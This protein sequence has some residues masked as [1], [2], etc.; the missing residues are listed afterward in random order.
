MPDRVI[1][2]VGNAGNISAIW[3]GFKE[4]D[5]LGFIDKLP[6]MTGIQA[7][8][9]APIARAIKNGKSEI[10]PVDKPETIASAIRIGAPVSWKKAMN[11]IKESKG[12]AEIVTDDEILEAQKLL[13]RSEGLFIE[14]ASAASIAGLKK[15]VETGEI[16]RDEVVVCV[17]TGHGLKD[18]DTAMKIS[19][20][21][22]EID[23]KIESV[24]KFLGLS[25]A[26]TVSVTTR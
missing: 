7:E 16:D 2:P 12:I 18:P 26:A 17:A 9:A 20:K 3:K 5:R 10:M 21:P 24:E 25:R 6:R 14:P 11:A 15:L 23:A 4:F 8:G 13:A 19:E 1:L 22:F